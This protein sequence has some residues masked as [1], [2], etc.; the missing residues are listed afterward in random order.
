M[1]SMADSVMKVSYVQVDRV[2]L[3]RSVHPLD[4]KYRYCNNARN[5]MHM[6]VNHGVVFAYPVIIAVR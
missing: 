4:Y 5:N 6:F 3:N 2:C 1:R